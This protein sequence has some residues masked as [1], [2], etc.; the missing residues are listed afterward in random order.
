[1]CLVPLFREQSHGYSCFLMAW[2]PTILVRTP[3]RPQPS[4]DSK[5]L[6][7]VIWERST[8]GLISPPDDEL[9]E[10]SGSTKP[11]EGRLTI[12]GED[13]PD[14]EILGL[15]MEQK[16]GS[17]IT[18]FHL[19]SLHFQIVWSWRGF[20]CGSCSRRGGRYAR[21][22]WSKKESN[23]QSQ[24]SQGSSKLPAQRVDGA[25]AFDLGKQLTDVGISGVDIVWILSQ[26]FKWSTKT[27]FSNS[28]H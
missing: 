13:P 18:V 21:Y 12:D 10:E 25:E 28:A 8:G 4:C 14:M 22:C 11:T 19:N 27:I 6:V 26:Q 16:S 1:M 5:T 17:K 7:P 24:N 2:P 20:R 9:P 23:R 15:K 3:F